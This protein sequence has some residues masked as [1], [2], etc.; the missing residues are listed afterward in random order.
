MFVCP[1]RRALSEPK[2]VR[3]AVSVHRSPFPVHRSPFAVLG[4]PLSNII[5]DFH[6]YPCKEGCPRAV[7][8]A[9]PWRQTSASRARHM[10]V[11]LP[12]RGVLA[13]PPNAGVPAA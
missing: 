3:A 10:L 11:Y 6:S 4:S 8:F 13:Y 12:A 2:H 7:R 9:M 1:I 5:F